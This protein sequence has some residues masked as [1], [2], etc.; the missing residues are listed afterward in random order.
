MGMD[1]LV[2]GSLAYDDIATPVASGKTL[3]GGSASHF[4]AAA[5]LAGAL[6]KIIA[7]IGDDF[8]SEDLDYLRALPADLEGVSRMPGQSFR[9]GGRYSDDFS[10][11]ETLFTKLGVFE[12]FKPELSESH[13]RCELLFLA[14]I[15]PA[16]QLDVLASATGAR[17]VALDTMN[18]WIETTKSLLESVISKVD[19]LFIND[20]EAR[21]LSGC[22]SLV[23]AGEAL[24]QMGPA[25]CLLKTGEHGGLLFSGGEIYPFPPFPVREVVDPTGAGDS[26]AG[27]VLGHL[28]AEGNL[29][30]DALRRAVATGAT[31]GSFAVEGLGVDGLRSID[32]RAFSARRELYLAKLTPPAI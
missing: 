10:S 5:A 23:S 16:L 14:N 15:H 25:H 4:S 24:L 27:G 30:S 19:L 31:L 22:R 1:L 11:R 17:F 8:R 18:L 2:V 13:K 32:R 9:W 21:Q 28:A 29:D 6:P 26:F 3:L 12:A 20:E 7:V